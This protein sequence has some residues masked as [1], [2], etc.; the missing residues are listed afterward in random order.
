MKKIAYLFSA[1][2][3]FALVSLSACKKDKDEPT[4]DPDPTAPSVTANMTTSNEGKVDV[5]LDVS[6]STNIA[7][8][9]LD[10]THTG[11]LDRIYIMKSEDNG[12]LTGVTFASITNSTGLTFEGGSS[13]YSFKVPA[14]T[15]S[16]TLEVPVSIRTSS[17][18]VSDVYYIWIT[19][20]TGSFLLPTKNRVL[21]AAKV[22]LKYDAS[23]STTTF[24]TA[25]VNVGDQTAVPGSLLVTSGQI[26]ALTT[27]NYNDAPESADIAVA[28]LDAGGTTKTNGSD[29]IYLVSPDIRDDLD[30]DLEPSGANTTYISLYAGT[31]FATITGSQLQALTVGTTQKALAVVGN[32]Y[33]FTTE[34]GKKGLLKVNSITDETDGDAGAVVNVT[35]KVLN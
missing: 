22:T 11:D 21:G 13:D 34:S 31:D 16:F 18:A 20:G 25:T 17:A 19:N 2:A 27:A 12:S 33:M 15:Q 29:Y 8:I 10:V 3:L 7:K 14:S 28:A 24:S 23:A 30:Y 9:K 35:V 26:S 1:T 6:N 32:V 5:S 4:P